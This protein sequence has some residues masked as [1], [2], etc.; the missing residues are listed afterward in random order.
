M[1]VL[2]REK[3]SQRLA[4]RQLNIARLAKDCGISRQS[5]YAMFRGE[6]IYNTP[7][8]KLIRYLQVE[9][10]DITEQESSAERLLKSAPLKIKKVVC[11]LQDFCRKHGASLL[12]FGS[13]VAGS[14]KPSS[15][16]DFAVY[17]L[18]RTH[19]PALLKLKHRLA[20]QAFP[21]RLD[22]VNLNQ[23]PSWFLESIRDEAQLLHGE[24]PPELRNVA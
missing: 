11:D 23:A 18:K 1:A 20:E 19:V 2:S 16:W 7:F 3:L 24:W 12:L 10:G 22:I 4:E 15:D 8:T 21:Y 14:A 13:Q 9:P 6:S 5:L 17:F